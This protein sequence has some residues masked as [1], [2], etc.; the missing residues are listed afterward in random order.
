MPYIKI[1]SDS[2]AAIKALDSNVITSLLVKQTNEALNKVANKAARLEICWII[3]HIGHEC[4]ERA[5]Q[6]AR[7]AAK[8]TEV[9]LRTPPSWSTYKQEI[10]TKIYTKWEHRWTADNAY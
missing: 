6:L 4:N 7:E 2:Q 3:A 8:C 5:D 9:R 10:K 1:F